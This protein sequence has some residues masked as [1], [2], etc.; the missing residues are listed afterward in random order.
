[1]GAT[2]LEQSGLTRAASVRFRMNGGFLVESAARRRAAIGRL[3]ALAIASRPRYKSAMGGAL[4][5]KRWQ[6][7]ITAGLVVFVV[8][9]VGGYA[10]KWK[11]TGYSDNDTLWEWLKLLLLPIILAT[12]PSGSRKA[13]KCAGTGA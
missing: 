6:L 7:A 4:A 3:D 8:T 5:Q 12:A 10:G 9:L 1:M 13:A 2:P 11:W